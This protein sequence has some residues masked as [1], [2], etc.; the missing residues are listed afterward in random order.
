MRNGQVE[1][2]YTIIQ[3]SRDKLNRQCDLSSWASARRKTSYTWETN[4]L[5]KYCSNVCGN[6]LVDRRLKIS[7][8]FLNQNS[9]HSKKR[10][11]TTSV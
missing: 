1:V 11:N 4:L 3:F 6:R 8:P 10:N 5:T 2:I 9:N 7:I